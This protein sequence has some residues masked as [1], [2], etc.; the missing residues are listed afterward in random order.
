MPT[1]TTLGMGVNID[2]ICR[3]AP[4]VID[5]VVE[6]RAH[7]RADAY[8]YERRRDFPCQLRPPCGGRCCRLWLSLSVAVQ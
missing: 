5:D 4:L 2:L 1:F 3:L 8:Y 7:D 6:S